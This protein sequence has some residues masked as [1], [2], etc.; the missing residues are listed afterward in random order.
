MVRQGFSLLIPLVLAFQASAFSLLGPRT[1]WMTPDLSYGID[2]SPGGPMNVGDE[3]RW[4]LPVITYGFDDAFVEYFG[5][6]GVAEVGQAIATLN[7]LPTASDLNLDAFPLSAVKYS[8]GADASQ[9]VDL[10]STALAALLEQAGLAA[11]EENVFCLRGKRSQPG[12]ATSYFVVKRNFDSATW[13]P[14]SYVNGTLFTYVVRSEIVDPTGPVDAVEIKVDPLAND[15]STAAGFFYW[16]LRP[17]YFLSGLSRDDVGGLRYLLTPDNH[18]AE[19][20]PANVTWQTPEGGLPVLVAERPGIGRLHFSRVFPDSLPQTNSFVDRYF[21]NGVLTMQTVKRVITKPDITFSVRDLGLN[22]LV[23]RSVGAWNNDGAAEPGNPVVADGPGV[24]EPGGL[25]IFN[26]VG[27][28]F[29]NRQNTGENDGFAYIGS[30]ASFDGSGNPPFIYPA[31]AEPVP[32]TTIAF[33]AKAQSDGSRL[34][35]WQFRG[36]IG[37]PH[38]ILASSDLS[39]WEPVGTATAPGGVFEFRLTESGSASARFYKAQRQ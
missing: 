32:V 2:G 37:Q 36:A 29:I 18:N 19:S 4:N 21:T 38:Q 9:L 10:R 17:G 5:E 7:D 23:R 39:H 33:Q 6:H 11:P 34:V 24:I 12:G 30:W 20:L 28:V 8:A 22:A 31:S 25:I 26:K 1:A 27:P 35:V 14:S 16:G 3:Y 15:Y 13:L